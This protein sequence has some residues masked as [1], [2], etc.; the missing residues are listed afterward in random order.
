MNMQ[1]ISAKNW[2]FFGLITTNLIVD[3]KML[4]KKGFPFL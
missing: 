1:A 3:Y 4:N 2:Q